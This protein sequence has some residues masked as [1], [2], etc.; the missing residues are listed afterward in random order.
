MTRFT[1][2]VTM[3]KLFALFL[4]LFLLVLAPSAMA[5]TT[6]PAN[7]FDPQ[8]LVE[9]ILAYLRGV[10]TSTADDDEAKPTPPIP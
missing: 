1:R 5:A 6:A 4:V 3:R 8:S 7:G 9:R 2:G 10:V